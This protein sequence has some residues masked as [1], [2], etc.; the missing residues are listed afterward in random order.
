[1][2]TTKKVTKKLSAVAKTALKI[3]K[4]ESSDTIKALKSELKELTQNFTEVK[5]AHQQLADSSERL[6]KKD[7]DI[8]KENT[9]LK[10]QVAIL[11]KNNNEAHDTITR[12][13]NEKGELEA[14]LLELQKLLE[15]NPK[16]DAAPQ[17]VAPSDLPEAMVSEE[18]V[19]ELVERS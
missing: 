3:Q 15:I 4:K 17:N 8:E 5:A 18:D 7:L 13:A 11:T 9:V 6:L 19:E 14:K 10:E 1:M 2:K 12:Q 16:E